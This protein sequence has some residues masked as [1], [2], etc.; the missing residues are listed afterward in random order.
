MG[1]L[2]SFK[3][4]WHNRQY[5]LVPCNAFYEPCYE[6][7]KAV[8]T[9]ISMASGQPFMIAGLWDRWHRDEE[10]FNSFTMLTIDA[11]GHAVMGKMHK[12]GDEK[13][14][15]VI[16]L[17]DNYERWLNA[18]PEEA[19]RILQELPA[20]QMSAVSAPLPP[21]AKTVRQ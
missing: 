5:C 19:F 12:P 2:R 10:Q 8:R 14:M 13:R 15:P 1:Q 9:R 21:R 17:E 3:N 11:D 6:T 20:N 4:P 18:V 16:L 7:G